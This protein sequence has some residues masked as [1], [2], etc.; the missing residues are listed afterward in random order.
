MKPFE[1]MEFHPA[2][3]QIVRLLCEKTQS[4]NVLFF[5]VQA[6]FH[7]CMLASQMR[8]S[9]HTHD[10]GNIPVNMYALN[11][12]TSGAGKGFSS[13][14]IQD[15]I[16]NQFRE[17]FM[18]NFDF[19]AEPHL[20]LLAS[21]RATRKGTVEED[22]LVAVKK[23][24]AEL[25]PSIYD[26]DD[27]TSAA[28]KQARHKLLMANIGALNMIVD[29]IG[30]NLLGR[31]DVTGPMMELYDVGAIKQKLTKVTAENKRTEEIKGK[32]P[33]NLLMFGTPSKLLDGGKVEEELM[34][35]LETGYARRCFFS[36]GKEA[37]RDQSLTPDQ[38]YDLLTNKASTK[39]IEDLSCRLGNLADM[40][41]MGTRLTMS[42]DV[43]L[44]IIEYRMICER[45]A[46]SFPEHDEIRK[47]EMAHRYF[48]ALKVAGV[49]AFV[50]ECPEIT[51]GHWENAIKLTE[52]CGK[53]FDLLLSRDKPYVKLANFI[54]TCG[55]ELTQPDLLNELPYY[56]RAQSQRNEMMSLAIAH[57]YKNNI[58]IKKTFADG[59][60]F[61]RGETLK[62]TDLDSLIMSYT[63]NP[64]MTQD[65]Q[66]VRAKWSSLG[67]LGATSDIHW[68]NH[69]VRGGYRNE[70]SAEV[71][72]NMIVLDIDGTMSLDTAKFLLQGQM[73]AF[74]TTKS[75][76]PEANRFRIIMPC[77]YELKLDRKEY[78]EFMKGVM[79]SLPFAVDEACAHRC[80]KW[81]S[82]TG[83]FEHQEGDL[84]DVLPFIPKTQKNEERKQ[85]L[86]NQQQL[87]NLERW[88][89]NN[90]GDGNRNNMILRY[91]TTLVD[92]GYDLAGAMDRIRDLNDKLPDKLPD[93]EIMSTVMKT[94]QQRILA[95]DAA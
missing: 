26:F 85:R 11:L 7:L 95:R 30:T 39:F 81:L 56:P 25:G 5:R 89:I 14:I 29:E 12:A 52:E 72:F 18:E 78:S 15:Y 82:N 66:N 4:P 45:T 93:M 46:A 92:A 44:S 87:D 22:E 84:F 75:H 48:K 32:T 64:N 63:K 37:V 65:Y 40:S 71:G 8:T 16:T 60:E 58:I 86:D 94:V 61:I 74:Y 28:L 79:A 51:M 34:S 80:K 21:R 54:A 90:T 19:A 53:A 38:I 42:K 68:L 88:F 73:C 77:N 50:D 69:H 17:N 49:Y 91:G 83:H 13:N 33:T 47:A 57:G 9:I 35:L 6:T 10:R 31:Q 24:Y 1:D 59:V 70:E 62:Q 55:M 2:T 27:A 43:A 67:M 20:E 36:Y 41:N 76:T 23:E 3:E